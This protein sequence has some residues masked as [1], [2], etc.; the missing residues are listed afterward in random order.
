ME[1]EGTECDAR[2]AKFERPR[3]AAPVGKSGD[4]DA[5]SVDLAESLGPL[6]SSIMEGSCRSNDRPTHRPLL[7]QLRRRS[8]DASFSKIVPHRCASVAWVRDRRERAIAYSRT[9]CS[10]GRPG[11]P[12]AVWFQRI[13]RWPDAIAIGAAGAE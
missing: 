2:A 8:R 5:H 9:S 12:V 10:A 6:A 4:K 13:I 7:Q 3:T 11:R 1:L